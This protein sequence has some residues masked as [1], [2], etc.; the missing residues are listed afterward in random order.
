MDAGRRA[1]LRVKLT[2]ITDI[3][4]P[5]ALKKKNLM[6]IPSINIRTV[7]AHD[8]VRHTT[9]NYA[10]SGQLYLAYSHDHWLEANTR[11]FPTFM[12][13]SDQRSCRSTGCLIGRFNSYSGRYRMR[14]R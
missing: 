12:V 11:Q 3:Q 6:L 2:F 4:A 13:R 5:A 7:F 8:M 9:V 10:V 1:D 14:G